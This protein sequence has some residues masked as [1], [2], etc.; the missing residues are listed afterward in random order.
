[1]AQKFLTNIDLNQNQLIKGQFESVASDPG[2]NNFEGRLIYNSTEKVIKVYTGTAWRKALHA[3][4]SETTAL[5]TSESNGTVTLTIAV[6]DA[7][8]AGLLSSTGFSLL[9]GATA[10]NTV[11]TLV[12]RDASGNFSAGTITASLTGNVSGNLTGDVTGTVSSLSNHTT[13]NLA[14]GTNLYYTDTRVRD[15][16]LDQLAAPTADVSFNS[17]KITNLLDPVNAQDA[18]T[19]AYVDAARSG[20]DVKDSV[21]VATTANITL[22]NLQTIDGVALA[23]GDRVLVKNQDTASEN[24]IYV[25]V[26]GDAW[27]RSTDAD[28][29]LEVTAGLFTFV[30]EGT[31]N[32]DSGWVLTT[33]NPITVGTTNLTFAQFSGAG[34][35][36]AGDG[37]SKTGNTIDVGG[38]TDRIT[39]TADSVDI[40]ST[41]VGQSS[42]TTLGTIGTGT[43]QGTAVAIEYGGTGATSASV[44]RTN[45]AD[46]PA[47]GLTTGTPVLARIASQLI[48]DGSNTAYTITHNL[49]TRDV[50]VQVFDAST[51]E[52]VVTDVVR[53]NTNSVTVTFS[54]APDSNAF[55]VVV[56]G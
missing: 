19:K 34:A 39:V 46:T 1:M 7:V 16:R 52:T 31:V 5:T 51:Y 20:L 43:W 21:R 8:N 11:S 53:T 4:S 28:T 6:A 44:A 14:E 24:G 18:A 56:T 54:V 22:S 47:S 2:T 30:E 37:L 48:G 9:N 41:Y 13:T 23:D 15:N 50:V 49:G 32:A 10:N 3:I 35:I 33:N 36:I 25:A 26:D 42:I 55:K 27:T 29:D 45:L 38:T 17:R 40:A 12:Q